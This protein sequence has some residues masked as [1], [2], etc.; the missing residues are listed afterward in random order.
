MLLSKIERIKDIE[1]PYIPCYAIK[2]NDKYYLVYKNKHKRLYYKIF[3]LWEKEAMRYNGLKAIIKKC[4][5]PEQ[6]KVD[7]EELLKI[8]YFIGS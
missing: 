3:R 4:E 7:F 6:K 2:I 8:S 1:D 5:D